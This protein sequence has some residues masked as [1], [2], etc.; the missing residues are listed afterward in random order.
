MLTPLILSIT[1]LPAPAYL[2]YKLDR[3][4]FDTSN[5]MNGIRIEHT[6]WSE[7][8]LNTG[9]FRNT[10]RIMTIAMAINW[11]ISVL[12]YSFLSFSLALYSCLYYFSILF[13]LSLLNDLPSKDN[14]NTIKEKF[15]KR[16]RTDL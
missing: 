11:A 7:K 10:F 15:S 4:G 14:M 5:V 3:R 12:K 16:Y 13:P 2:F 6:E 1:M 9:H 8:Y